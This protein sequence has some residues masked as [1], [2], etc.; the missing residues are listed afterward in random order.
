METKSKKYIDF[1]NLEDPFMQKEELENIL[2]G[3]Q[4]FRDKMSFESYSFIKNTLNAWDFRVPH[5]IVPKNK[6]LYRCR[7]NEEEQDY[8]ER[9]DD[10]SIRKDILC[11]DRKS[12][13]LNSS[14]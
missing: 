4:Y 5:L 8:F 14:H 9:I 11:I 13:R 10:I 7:R 3:I 12:T 1:S 2:K 6:L